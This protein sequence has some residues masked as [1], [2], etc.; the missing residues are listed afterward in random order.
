MAQ[1]LEPAKVVRDV[2]SPFTTLKAQI[3]EKHRNK[4][5]NQWIREELEPRVRKW[6]EADPVLFTANSTR[7]LSSL[8]GASPQYLYI[9]GES[10]TLPSSKSW[11][12]NLP[13]D[14]VQLKHLV[15]E[16]TDEDLRREMTQA[17]GLG[18]K[19]KTLQGLLTGFLEGFTSMEQAIFS[20]PELKS[21]APTK[22]T[23][24]KR[25]RVFKVPC[26]DLRRLMMEAA[27]LKEA[28]NVKG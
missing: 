5:V 1:K 10:Y 15:A 3:E 4:L 2:T 16:S 17:Q 19:A 22:V 26:N 20:L 13:S 7:R 11:P 23:S 27:R 18:E 28:L 9:D 25:P 12:A 6:E 8:R 24:Q 14:M 21:F